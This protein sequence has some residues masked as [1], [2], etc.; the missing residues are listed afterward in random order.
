MAVPASEVAERLLRAAARKALAAR[1]TAALVRTAERAAR[2]EAALAG[3]LAR[4]RARLSRRAEV[5]ADGLCHI[6]RDALEKRVAIPRGARAPNGSGPPRRYYRE[7]CADAAST[8]LKRLRC[9]KMCCRSYRQHIRP[10][11]VRP[12]DRDHCRG[13]ECRVARRA[14]GSRGEALREA[15]GRASG[16]APKKR[17]PEGPPR[18]APRSAPKKEAMASARRRKGILS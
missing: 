7:S 15:A 14:P 8:P 1:K 9:Q 4:A 18:S 6:F 11:G 10:K 16:S 5:T 17:A 3:D 12:G 2:A 13:V